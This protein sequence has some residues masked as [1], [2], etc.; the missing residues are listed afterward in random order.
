[1][2]DAETTVTPACPRCAE[3]LNPDS[4]PAVLCG[5][6]GWRGRAFVFRP[7]PP[8]VHHPQR[9]LPDDAVCLHHP[10]K[11]AVSVCAGTG[12]YICAL[13]AVEL[14]GQTYSAAFLGGAGRDV[15][16]RATDRYLPRPDRL[17]GL[18]ALVSL[19]CLTAP[20]LLP[21][22]VYGYYRVF[23]VRRDSEL[24]RRV[25]GPPQVAWATVYLLLVAA[26]GVF[27]AIFWVLSFVQGT[28]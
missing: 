12:D 5:R 15:W 14:D 22:A 21:F 2:T 7:L 4:G 9:A 3:R 25:I 20:F 6:C 11:R 18:Y 28:V 16:R 13:C 10:D 23:R 8:L 19:L 26:F 27:G 24:H 17:L 1:M